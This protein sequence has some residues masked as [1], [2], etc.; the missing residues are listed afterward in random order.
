MKFKKFLCS[1]DLEW[2][3]DLMFL[4]SSPRRRSRKTSTKPHS[5]RC[6]LEALEDRV[7]PANTYTVTLASD[8]GSFSSGTMDSSDPSGLSGD[9]RYT[10]LQADK[11][12]NA[13]STIHFSN[14]LAG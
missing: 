12:V 14:K 3:R 6:S 1:L 9:L 4:A 2:F 5:R 11:S 8:A 13:G 7:V 10:I